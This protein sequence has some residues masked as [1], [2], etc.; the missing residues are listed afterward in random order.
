MTIFFGMSF[1]TIFN[2]PVYADDK[3]DEYFKN[4]EAFINKKQYDRAV[5]QL[6]KVIEK[7]EKNITARLLIG[8]IKFGQMS[9][10]ETYDQIRDIIKIEPENK[11]A[12]ELGNKTFFEVLKRRDFNSYRNFIFYSC[13]FVFGTP[14]PEVEKFLLHLLKEHQKDFINAQNQINEKGNITIHV[15]SNIYTSFNKVLPVLT[16]YFPY[17]NIEGSYPARIAIENIKED[18]KYRKHPELLR[19]DILEFETIRH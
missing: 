13:N 14:R 1:L 2:S 7:S 19:K 9:F 11:D 17:K 5:T 4:A 3:L 10:E 18:E 16:K 6:N 12:I 8:K 15:L